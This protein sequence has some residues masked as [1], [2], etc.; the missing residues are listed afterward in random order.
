MEKKLEE[1][2]TILNNQ[3]EIQHIILKHMLKIEEYLAIV[4]R[5]GQA[6]EDTCAGFEDRIKNDSEKIQGNYLFYFNSRFKE[7][8]K[9]RTYIHRKQILK[10]QMYEWHIEYNICGP[11]R[12]G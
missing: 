2:T 3:N 4:F 9:I 5:K 8:R 11:L 1:I 6:N 7:I 10:H 12:Y